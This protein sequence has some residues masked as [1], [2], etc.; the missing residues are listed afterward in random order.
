MARR[1]NRLTA[2][3]VATLGEGYHADGGGLYLQVTASGARSWIFRY[4]VGKRSR[5]MG[6]GSARDVTLLE[7]RERAMAARR[8]RAEGIDPI[9]ARAAARV[10]PSR[11]WGQAADDFIDS[12]KTEWRTAQK[13]KRVKG[14]NGELIGS[15]ENQWRQSLKDYGP[16]RDMLVSAITTQTILDALRPIWKARDQGGK[17][18]TATRVR[19][20]IERVW[21]AER[22]AGNVSGENPARWKG[23]LQHLLPAPEKLKQTKHHAALPYGDA[24]ALYSALRFR[25]SRTARALRFLLLT[26]ARTDEVTGMPDLGEVDFDKALWLIPRGRMKADVDH[27]VPLVPEALEL[28]QGLPKDK[29]PFPLSENA[30]LNLLQRPPPKGLGLDFTVHGLRSTFRDWVSETTNH[31]REVAEMSLAH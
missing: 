18:E 8:Q 23:H 24:P 7:A 25:T 17:P 15:Q 6:M 31:P 30:M 14:E 2:R 19:G 22:V 21:E 29:P 20:R 16:R 5:D 3:Q 26:A 13:G 11:T 10:Q 9:D 12:K 4:A 28:L 27:E 1:V